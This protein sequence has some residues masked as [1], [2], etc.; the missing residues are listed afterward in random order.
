MKFRESDVCII[1]IIKDIQKLIS[2]KLDVIL[3]FV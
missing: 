2:K 3:Q 1:L